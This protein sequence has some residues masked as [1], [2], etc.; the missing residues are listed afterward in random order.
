VASVEH[1]YI[2]ASRKIQSTKT[3]KV[4]QHIRTNNLELYLTKLV[5]SLGSSEAEDPTECSDIS[6]EEDPAEVVR[7]KILLEM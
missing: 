5:H 6:L 3:N 1:Q 4:F 2:L 7:K